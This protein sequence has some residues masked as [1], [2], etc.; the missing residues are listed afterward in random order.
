[1]NALGR[2]TTRVLA[3]G[4]VTAA[5]SLVAATVLDAGAPA[6]AAPT[7]TEP[8]PRLDHVVLIVFENHERDSVLGSGAAPTFDQLAARYAQATNARAVT[9]PS[10]PN[11]LALISG[12]THGVT[13]DCV[14]CPQTG[15]TIGSLLTD[16]R[17]RWGNFAEGFP[18]DAAF[19][20]KH[21]P[22]LYFARDAAHVYPLTAFRPRNLP[23]FALVTPNLCHDMHDCPIATGDAWLARFVR[24]LL[25]IPRTAIFITFDEGES[26]IGGGGGGGTIA[27]I[28]AGTAVKPH[29]E[30]NRVISHYGLLRTIENALGLPPLGAAAAVA[31][32][33]GIWR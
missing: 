3:L 33:T 29:S 9:H 13:T 8:V 24:P 31:P 20:K 25:A 17:R 15:P 27:S 30:F 32:M 18:A 28:I 16:R 23:A 21:V 22:F 12:S 14:D 19:A 26:R 1:M 2:R 5:L 11:Y 4:V 7:V 6:S 10:L